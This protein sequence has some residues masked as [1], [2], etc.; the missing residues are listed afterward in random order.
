MSSAIRKSNRMSFDDF[1]VFDEAATTRHELIGGTVFAMSGGTDTH[2]LICTNLTLLIAAPLKGRCQTFQGQMKLRVDHVSDSDSYYPDIMVTCA[3]TDR[4]KLFRREP[5]LL[6]EV[7]SP[8]TARLDR[9]EKRLNYMQVPSLLDYVLVSQD[10]PVV[11]VMRRRTGWVTE[12]F[13][14]PDTVSLESVSLTLRVAD[15][16]DGISFTGNPINSN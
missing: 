7:L 11:E 3:P 10:V 9:G 6:I 14:L 16:Y 15:I 4:D 13:H 2:N 1:L 12:D 8:S 5:I